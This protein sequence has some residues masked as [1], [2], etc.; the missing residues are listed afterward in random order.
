MSVYLSALLYKIERISTL[1]K[2]INKDKQSDDIT[3][4]PTNINVDSRKISTNVNIFLEKHVA[5]PQNSVQSFLNFLYNSVE[6][7]V[8]GRDSLNWGKLN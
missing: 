6:K 2:M 7:T 4:E 1:D 5:K 3:T 8:L